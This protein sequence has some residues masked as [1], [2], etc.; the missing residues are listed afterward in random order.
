VLHGGTP[1]LARAY[2]T[3]TPLCG[4]RLLVFGGH[5]GELRTF[6]EAHV[7]DL[8]CMMWHH[9]QVTG[10]PPPPRTGHVATCLDGVRVM[11]HGGWE[12]SGDGDEADYRMHADLSILDTDTWVWTRPKVRGAPPCP[13][14]GHSLAPHVDTRD[15]S[16]SLYLFGG[17]ARGDTPL[18]D[19]F[20]LRPAAAKSPAPLAASRTPASGPAPSSS[21][22]KSSSAGGKSGSAKSSVG[23]SARKAAVH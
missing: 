4:Q 11:V 14:V 6:V 1:P 21:G 5:D 7:L 18:N 20:R 13:R 23:R 17:R 10:T 12:P 19:T 16:A 3:A 8:A 9:P 2:H 15:G 22:G